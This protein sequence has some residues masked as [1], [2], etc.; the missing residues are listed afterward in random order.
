M[1]WRAAGALGGGCSVRLPFYAR[2]SGRRGWPASRGFGWWAATVVAAVR[3]APRTRI[4]TPDRT[5]HAS[6]ASARPSPMPS[7][8]VLAQKLTAP[9]WFAHSL[10]CRGGFGFADGVLREGHGMV[11]WRCE[12]CLLLLA[13]LCG[14]S[15]WW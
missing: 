14:R 6:N 5:M 11:W 2:G 4:G 7:Q 9:P 15:S 13:A 8:L 1:P 12:G 3:D 10:A